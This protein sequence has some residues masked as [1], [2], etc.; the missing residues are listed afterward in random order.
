MKELDFLYRSHLSLTL[1]E[2]E[3]RFCIVINGD[4][5]VHKTTLAT[6]LIIP[7]LAASKVIRSKNSYVMW[8]EQDLT[9]K[10]ERLDN[11]EVVVLDDYSGE[12][13]KLVTLNKLTTRN[14][15]IF[16]FLASELWETTNLLDS[17]R[18]YHSCCWHGGN[19]DY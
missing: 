11:K 14:L 19:L 1:D 2:A 9:D 13:H 6:K 3:Q 16:V 10:L 15:L 18:G 7:K 12:N 17:K 8:E 4:S 5:G